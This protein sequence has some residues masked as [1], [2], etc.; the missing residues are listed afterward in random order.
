MIG[1]AT[2]AVT[3]NGKPQTMAINE[4]SLKNQALLLDL[5]VVESHQLS[6]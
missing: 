6:N 4:K 5:V 2:T 1:H 3:A